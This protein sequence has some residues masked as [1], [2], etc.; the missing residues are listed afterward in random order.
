MTPRDYN[1]K[2]LTAKKANTCEQFDSEL[3]K[4]D[5]ADGTN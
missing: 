1:I 5:S 2:E 4:T 3:T